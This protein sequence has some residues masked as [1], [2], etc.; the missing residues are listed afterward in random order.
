MSKLQ[1]AHTVNESIIEL[2]FISG[3]S[4][5]KVNVRPHEFEKLLKEADEKALYMR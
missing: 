3:E 5:Q 1:A 4:Q 2:K